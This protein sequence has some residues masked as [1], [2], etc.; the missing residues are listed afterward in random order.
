MRHPNPLAAGIQRGLRRIPSQL[1]ERY[2]AA[3]ELPLPVPG[4]HCSTCVAT[5][6]Y[7]TPPPPPSLTP[8]GQGAMDQVLAALPIAG[9]IVISS[10][11]CSEVPS[12]PTF[13]SPPAPIN[14][15]APPLLPQDCCILFALGLR[16]DPHTALLRTPRVSCHPPPLPS[17]PLPPPLSVFPCPLPP[18]PY[19]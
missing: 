5:V 1:S 10:T 12:P 15:L 9:A 2:A 14:P 4:V 18:P 13:T 7:S 17:S 6:V 8:F 19:Q 16:D 11:I 3:A